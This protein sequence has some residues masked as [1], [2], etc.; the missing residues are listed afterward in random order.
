MFKFKF[1]FKI[2]KR[3]HLYILS[4]A[5]LGVLSSCQKDLNV[6][7][8]EHTPRLVV[9]SFLDPGK[10]VDVYLSRSYGPLEDIDKLDLLIKDAVVEIWKDEQKLQTFTYQDTTVDMFDFETG[11][12]YQQQLGKYTDPDF[13]VEAGQTYTLKVSHPDYE[14][15]SARTTAPEMPEIISAE[16]EQ[17]VAR[18]TS[19][20]EFSAAQSLLHIKIKDPS[21]SGE[22]YFIQID[23]EYEDPIEP[24]LWVTESLSEVAGPVARRNHEGAYEVETAW[25]K[26]DSRSGDTVSGDI[27]VILP[28]AY[29]ERSQYK[30]LNIRNMLIKLHTVNEESRLYIDELFT[31]RDNLDGFDIFPTESVVVYNNIEN[32]YGIFGGL[33][34]STKLFQY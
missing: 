3:I 5:I 23:L 30:P 26:D 28:Y 9:N 22:S 4:V 20:G 8:P 11:G 7:M 2:M 32:G 1:K 31:Q 13:R 33:I 12:T 25:L 34:K 10:P 27:L 6:P 17:N 29:M 21:L 15:V 19:I 16:I 24:G 18:E 14:D